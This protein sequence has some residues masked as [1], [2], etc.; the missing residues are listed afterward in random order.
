MQGH[1]KLNEAEMDVSRVPYEDSKLY[2]TML[3]MAIARKWPDVYSNAVNP[4]WV[5]TKMGGMGAPD[6]LDKGYETQV[7]LAASDDEN[8]KVSGRYFF[9]QQ[10]SRYHADAE[11]ASLQEALLDICGEIS[12]IPFP[13]S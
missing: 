8:A 4:G 11:N 9:H 5:P 2:V 3:S 13:V 7:W 10:E 1:Y 6:D 12:G